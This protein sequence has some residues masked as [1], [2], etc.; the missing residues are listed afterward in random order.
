MVLKTKKKSLSIFLDEITPSDQNT[1]EL[2]QK[3]NFLSL[4]SRLIC[5]KNIDVKVH[6]KR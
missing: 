6:M 1:L 4:F 2:K 5:Q 3:V